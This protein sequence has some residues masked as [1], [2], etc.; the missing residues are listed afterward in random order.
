MNLFDFMR[1]K[2]QNDAAPAK[3][4]SDYLYKE[5]SV[6][7]IVGKGHGNYDT[8]GRPLVDV[9]CPQPRPTV[10]FYAKVKVAKKSKAPQRRNQRVVRKSR[11]K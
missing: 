1:D 2:S 5:E 3:G 7:T 11:I 10:A 4:S 9:V 6:P 8:F